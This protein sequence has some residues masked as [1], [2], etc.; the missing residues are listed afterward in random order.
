M[1]PLYLTAI[2]GFLVGLA[3]A[4][5]LLLSFRARHKARGYALGYD[6]AYQSQ[7]R[8]LDSCHARIKALHNDAAQHHQLR[9]IEKRGHQTAIEAIMQ[10]ADERIALYARRS[11]PLNEKDLADL[12]ALSTLLDLAAATFAGVRAHDKATL[13]RNLQQRLI[14]MA[15]RLRALHGMHAAEPAAEGAEA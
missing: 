10:D 6:A 1:N 8:L 3:A 14:N 4:I 13:T 7:Q 15:Q 2:L 12:D 5:P 9:E 11:N